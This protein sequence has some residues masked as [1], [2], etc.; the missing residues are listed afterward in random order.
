MI[1]ATQFCLH[2]SQFYLNF[3]SIFLNLCSFTSI[4]FHLLE[5]DDSRINLH[6]SPQSTSI[7]LNF[8]SVYLQSSQFVSIYFDLGW[9]T[10]IYLKLRWVALGSALHCAWPQ[11]E[12][13]PPHPLAPAW[14]SLH[15]FRFGGSRGADPND[16]MDN[17]L[18]SWKRA[19]DCSGWS[20]DY[21]SQ[22]NQGVESC[23]WNEPNRLQLQG[24]RQHSAFDHRR[25]GGQGGRSDPCNLVS[26]DPWSHGFICSGRKSVL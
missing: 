14:Y 8:A 24:L 17:G 23:F 21:A 10:S 7:Y 22:H 9:F 25:K 26:Q 13:F 19:S 16:R 3:T 20:A 1:L 5:Y 11:H 4:F 2:L 15:S 6:H 12:V 18:L